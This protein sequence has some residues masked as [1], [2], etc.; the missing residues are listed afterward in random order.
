MFKRIDHVE[1]IPSNFDRTLAF[2]T[3][4]L[5]FKMGERKKVVNKPP[6]EEICY[7]KLGDTVLELML[8]TKP[9]PAARETWQV[10]YKRIA[11]EVEDMEQAV[12]HLQSKGVKIAVPPVNMGTSIRGEF[13][14]PDGLSIELRQWL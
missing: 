8:V 3:G 11:L 4:V 13:S 9:A 6:L 10:G 1:L 12:Q 7:L 5:G 2:Y 14:D